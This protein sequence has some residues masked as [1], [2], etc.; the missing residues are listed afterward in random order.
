M[1]RLET[2]NSYRNGYR[3]GKICHH[4]KSFLLLL[5][6]LTLSTHS[7]AA[8]VIVYKSPT[9][10]CCNDWVKHLQ[11]NGFSVQ[12]HDRRDMQLVKCTLN[13]PQGLQSC[14]TAVVGDY[15][16]EGH[17]PAKEIVRLL[18]EKPAVEGISVPGMPMGSPGMEGPRR[19]NQKPPAERVV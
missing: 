18:R 12:A 2:S 8:D 5:A 3:A 1:I 13:V 19:D 6:A 10:G 7:F 16:V 17:V 15:V 4:F 9:C 14:H 11:Q